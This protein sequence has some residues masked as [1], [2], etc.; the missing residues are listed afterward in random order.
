VFLGETPRGKS[1]SDG[2][3]QKQKKQ[4]EHHSFKIGTWNLRT[5]NKEGSLVNVKKE[6]KKNAVSVLGVSEV[7]W[8]GQDKIRSG[9]CSVLFRG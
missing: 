2:Y 6:M 3:K 8:K 4:K 5:L 9:D 1:S 7:R